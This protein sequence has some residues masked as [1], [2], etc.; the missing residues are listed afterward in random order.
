M[1]WYSVEAVYS[2]SSAM[3]NTMALAS[4]QPSP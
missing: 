3:P 2:S 4:C 1:A